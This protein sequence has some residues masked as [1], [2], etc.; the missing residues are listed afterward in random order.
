M[1]DAASWQQHQ[2]AFLIGTGL[3]LLGAL[4]TVWTTIVRDDGQGMAYFMIVI[5]IG[6]GWFAAHFSPAGMARTMVGVALAQALLAVATATAPIVARVPG[7]SAAA[8]TFGAA[9]AALWL[10]SAACFAKAAR[11]SVPGDIGI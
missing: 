10:I 6:I 3:A 8:L 9:F 4:L 1:S 11:S 5:S 2:P 7:A